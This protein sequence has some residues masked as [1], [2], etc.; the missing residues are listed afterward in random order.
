MGDGVT[1]DSANILNLPVVDADDAVAITPLGTDFPL[2]L[3]VPAGHATVTYW[4]SANLPGE[5][6]LVAVP[7]GADVTD[8]NQWTATQIVPVQPA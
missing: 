4:L 6:Q 1:A 5:Y 3:T 2:T 7:H 8:P